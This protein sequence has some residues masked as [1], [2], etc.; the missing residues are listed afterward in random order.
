MS[1]VGHSLGCHNHLQVPDMDRPEFKHQS[2]FYFPKYTAL[3]SS[4][5]L[6]CFTGSS[7][8]FIFSKVLPELRCNRRW[9][10]AVE[11]WSSRWILSR[12]CQKTWCNH[13][14]SIITSISIIFSSSGVIM[15]MTD[16]KQPLQS[17]YLICLTRGARLS[18]AESVR[19]SQ[20][21]KDNHWGLKSDD[22]V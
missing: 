15:V 3:I 20:P 17:K 22:E 9:T 7:V 5:V 8:A 4:P 19:A 18:R 12:H 6:L 11:F 10:Q 2:Y 1:E 16:L 21:D 14:I 13:Y